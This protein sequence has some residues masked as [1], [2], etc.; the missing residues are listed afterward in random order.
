MNFGSF[1]LNLR[2]KKLANIFLRK[3]TTLT[4][5]KKYLQLF[6]FFLNCFFEILTCQ[7]KYLQLFYFFLNCFFEI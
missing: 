4:C 6:Y 1:F 7:K 2:G 5:Q 3:K